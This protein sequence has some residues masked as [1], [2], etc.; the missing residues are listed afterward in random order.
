MSMCAGMTA[1]LTRKVEVLQSDIAAL[2][3]EIEEVNV[4]YTAGKEEWGTKFDM[5]NKE[6]SDEGVDY[7]DYTFVMCE[8]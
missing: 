2:E 5:L 3:K 4:V 8:D 7:T 6:V 1:F